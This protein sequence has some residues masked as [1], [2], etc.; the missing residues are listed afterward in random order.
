[1]GVRSVPCERCDRAPAA[2]VG[3]VSAKWDN[4][5]TCPGGWSGASQ[6][7]LFVRMGFGSLFK[8]IYC[9]SLQEGTYSR[10][11]VGLG[12]LIL[13]GMFDRASLGYIDG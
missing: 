6:T 4:N 10:G 2:Q 12:M 5:R 7:C 13:A 1:M 11:G 8:N 3:F 9:E